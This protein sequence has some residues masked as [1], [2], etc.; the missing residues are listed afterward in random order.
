M[1]HAY[2]LLVVLD[3]QF[4]S[5]QVIVGLLIQQV[6]VVSVVED[7]LQLSGAS[8][9]VQEVLGKLFTL[10]R[11]LLVLGFELVLHLKKKSVYR[12]EIPLNR[13]ARTWQ[14]KCK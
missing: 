1:Y 3:S 6:G 2:L 12:I 5:C 7:H 8:R 9:L 13:P 10:L 14:L 4:E 11:Q